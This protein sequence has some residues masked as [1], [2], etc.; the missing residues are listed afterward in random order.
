ME[1]GKWKSGKWKVG[2]RKECRKMSEEYTSFTWYIM[3]FAKGMEEYGKD[4]EQHCIDIRSLFKHSA[5]WREDYKELQYTVGISSSSHW[6]Q[7]TLGLYLNICQGF[8]KNAKSAVNHLVQ[9]GCIGAEWR[10][11][12]K[13]KTQLEVINNVFEKFLDYFKEAPFRF[14]FS[15]IEF[16]RY[17]ESS[18]LDF[19]REN[20]TKTNLM[21][22]W[23]TSIVVLRVNFLT[24][25]YQSERQQRL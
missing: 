12:H 21:A 10:E 3:L 11:K 17:W 14:T 6:S 7:V 25:T 16:L 5:A 22:I 23:W 1:S 4:M 19:S 24:V 8:G 13:T 15:V 9:G 18:W 2:R 20:L